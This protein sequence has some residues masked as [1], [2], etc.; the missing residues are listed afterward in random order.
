P[1][2]AAADFFRIEIEGQSAH[3]GMAPEK[4]IDTIVIASQLVSQLQTI[5]ARNVPPMDTGVVS[6][7]AIEGGTAPNIIADRVVMR[8]TVRALT[9]ATHEM[10]H[11][12]IRALCAGLEVAHPGAK[13]S[14]HLK[15]GVPPTVNDPEIAEVARA[16][17]RK[18]FAPGQVSIGEPIMAGEDFSYIARAVPS[19]FALLGTRVTQG[20]VH[21]LHT[22]KMTVNEDAL[23]L[24]A[25]WLAQTA[26]DLLAA[27]A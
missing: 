2:M 3:A 6:V 10:I 8:G 1:V 21:P 17:A 9:P 19:V 7:G 18:V 24:G 4:G 26:V 13:L 11:A 16:A 14:Y 12:R 15:H 20:E 22:P 23:P 5:V 27:A 25:A